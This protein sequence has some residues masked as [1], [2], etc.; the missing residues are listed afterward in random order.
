MCMYIGN[1][2]QLN[3]KNLGLLSLSTILCSNLLA[4]TPADVKIPNI[5]DAIKQSIP[6]KLDKEEVKKPPQLEIINNEKE[7]LVLKEGEKIYIKDFYLEN[8]QIENKNEVDKIALSELL[9]TYK[10]KNLNMKDISELSSKISE[11]YKTKGYMLA[12]AY[13]PKQNVKNQD[14]VLVIKIILGKYGNVNINNNS[15]VNNIRLEKTIKSNLVKDEAVNKN[16]LEKT[17][18][19]IGRMPGTAFPK[20]TVQP[21]SE[22]GQSDFLFDVDKTKRIEGYALVDNQGSIYTGEYRT[23]AGVS[24]NSPLQIADKLNLNGMYTSGGGVRNI[25]VTYSLPILYSGL[26]LELSYNKTKTDTNVKEYPN[27]VQELLNDSIG[28]S[29]V[30]GGKITYPLLLSQLETLEI[31]LNA[32][33]IEKENKSTYFSYDDEIVPKNINVARF[34]T[35][36]EKFSSLFGL[37]LYSNLN[38]ELS[39]GEVKRDDGIKKDVD[40]TVGNYSKLFL[41]YNAML[42]LNDKSS[43]TTNLKLQKALGNKSLDDFEQLTLSGISG[44]KVF[45]DSEYSADTGYSLS[46]EYKY[47]LPEIFSLKHNVGFFVEAARGFFE[48]KDFNTYRESRTLND[49]GIS[50]FVNKDEF[51]L[52]MKLAQIIGSEKVESEN[53]YDRRFLVSAGMMF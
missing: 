21:G 23:M 14:N 40:D 11:L 26:N 38:G 2:K 33:R 16:E 20:I 37:N 8:E 18:L 3:K 48:N 27:D 30:Y 1:L 39:F 45:P 10:D 31:Y 42:N 36:Y 53:D 4:A 7:P 6:P 5:S 25:G 22:F 35:S 29:D 28:D 52:N 12:K 15:Y 19:L 43:L 41:E 51:F 13:I 50:Y 46:L 9:N 49:V 17:M 47:K 32:Q 34:G 44:V 24:I